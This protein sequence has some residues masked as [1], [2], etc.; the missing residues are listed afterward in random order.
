LLAFVCHVV[1]CAEGRL[2]RREVAIVMQLFEGTR[3]KVDVKEQSLR[4]LVVSN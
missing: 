3:G 2:R 4:R 1:A